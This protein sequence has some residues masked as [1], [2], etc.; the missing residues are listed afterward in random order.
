MSKIWSFGD[1]FTEGRC[2]NVIDNNGDTLLEKTYA[3]YFLKKHNIDSI[4]V[5]ASGG[6]SRL[7]IAGR[8]LN[9]I[10]KVKKNDYVF[11]SNTD[12]MRLTILP[13]QIGLNDGIMKLDPNNLTPSQ[14]DYLFTVNVASS[15]IIKNEKNNHTEIL[16]SDELSIIREFFLKIFLKYRKNYTNY[17]NDFLDSAINS[18]LDITPNVCVIDSSIWFKKLDY[19]AVEY[20]ETPTDLYCECGHWNYKLHEIVSILCETAIKNN[21]LYITADTCDKLWSLFKK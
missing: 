2:S 9:K 17:F 1:S 4:E 21:E 13:T 20:F 5:S 8:I 15:F 6:S 3:H 14:R 12:S 16:S 11:I 19:M 10:G 7:D 18:L